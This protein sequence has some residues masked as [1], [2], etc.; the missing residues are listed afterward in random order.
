MTIWWFQNDFVHALNRNNSLP[1][2]GA[3]SGAGASA[4]SGAGAG[5]ASGAGAAGASG[6]MFHQASLC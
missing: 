5:A 2:A 1:G 6:W 3:A 4:A